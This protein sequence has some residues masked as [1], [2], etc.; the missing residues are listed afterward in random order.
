MNDFRNILA[1]IILILFKIFDS[2]IFSKAND[3]AISVVGSLESEGLK[4][5]DKT[6]KN[7]LFANKFSN[8]KVF[9]DSLKNLFF[10]IL[11]FTL[12]VAMMVYTG[13]SGCNFVIFHFVIY[14]VGFKSYS[15][16][17]DHLSYRKEQLKSESQF[18]DKCNL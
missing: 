15:E 11:C 2:I 7:L 1:L 5:K 16:L 17:L 10:M 14:F 8:A 13:N 9:K 3:G 6:I 4:C 18:F 12:A